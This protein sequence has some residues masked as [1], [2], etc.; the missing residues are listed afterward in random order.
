MKLRE[1]RDIIGGQIAGN[2]EV[3][4]TGVSGIKDAKQ[5]D[6]TFL[7][8]KKNLKDAYAAKASA[9][10]VKEAIE[11]LSSSMLI[12]EKPHLAFAMALGVFYKKPFKPLGISDKAVIGR[13][14]SLG[15]DVTV[16]PL[17]H[18]ND[19][20]SIGDRVTIFPGV[21]IGEDVSIGNDTLIYPNVTIRE[22]VKIGKGVIVHSGTVIGADGFGYVQEKGEHIKIPQ[23]GGVIVEDSVEIGAGVT[24][25]RA[26]IGN[27]IIGCGTK[28][29]NLVQIAHNVTIGRNCIIIAQ[30]AIGGSA[31]VGDGTMIGGQAAIRDHIKIGSRVMIGAQSGIGADIADG[32]VYSGSPAIPHKDWLRAQSIY[33]K[34]PEILSRLREL[35]RKIK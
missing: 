24:I 2:P 16:Y 19:R 22:N 35:E 14:V 8:D 30:V 29:D 25:D 20:V 33:A 12:V 27:T 26:T 7:A 34:L 21:Y 5:G 23:V 28:I 13:E 9:V 11:G 18:I 1:L 6:I 4:I 3:D 15:S 32:Q 10:I 17:A 31:E